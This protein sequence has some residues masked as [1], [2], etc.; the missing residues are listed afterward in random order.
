M[1]CSLRLIALILP[2]SLSKRWFPM[3]VG[4]TSRR[5]SPDSVQGMADKSI[6]S[7]FTTALTNYFYSV[8]INYAYSDDFAGRGSRN[9]SGPTL[10]IF[11]A[12]DWLGRRGVARK[13]T[14]SQVTRSPAQDGDVAKECHLRKWPSIALL[15]M[16]RPEKV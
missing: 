6:I 16:N 4:L 11:A 13:F 15:K 7:E 3:C 2:C 9:L 8:R 12:D 14:A 5:H 1:R 10:P